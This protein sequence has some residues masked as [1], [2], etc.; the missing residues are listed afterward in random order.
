MN[1]PYL[2]KPG[3]CLKIASLCLLLLL[4]MSGR[5]FANYDYINISDPF[6]KRIP[7]AIPVPASLSE[8]RETEAISGRVADLLYR[9]LDFT[10]YFTMIDSRAFLDAPGRQGIATSEINFKNWR[11]IGAEL[12]ITGGVR[13]ED[14]ILQLEF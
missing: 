11:D 8:N 7:I 1:M 2:I 4:A 5:G 10:G 14:R 6:Q 12:L 3:R 13:L 9:S